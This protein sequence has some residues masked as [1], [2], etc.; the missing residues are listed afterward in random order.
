MFIACSLHVPSQVAK[1]DAPEV[2]SLL[3]KLQATLRTN[4]VAARAAF[5][6][7][8]DG[9]ADTNTR[10]ELGQVGATRACFFYGCRRSHDSVNI[11]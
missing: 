4:Q 7:L 10:L 6:Q 11:Q 2:L 9:R 1:M 5:D 3:R 8:A